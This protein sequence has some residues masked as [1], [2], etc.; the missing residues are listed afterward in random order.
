MIYLVTNSKELFTNDTYTII[1]VEESLKLLEPLR[2]VGLDT[3]TDGLNCWSNKLK[4]IQLG[5]YDFQVVIDCLT[6]SPGKYKSYLESDRLFIGHNIKFDLCFLFRK[7]IWPRNVY[8]TYLGEKLLWLG[9]PIKLKPEVWSRIQCDRYTAKVSDSGNVSGYILEMNLKK[10]G[11]LYLGIELDKT[12]R[13][14]IIYAGLT[15]EVVVY[16][17]LDV[18]Y[19]E[20][21]MEAQKKKL[22]EQRLLNAIKYE[23]AFTVPLAY[24]E[25]CGV[26]INTTK[27]KAKMEKDNQRKQALEEQLNKWLITNMPK[28]KYITV[29]TQ[30]NLFEGFDTKPKVT[31][32]WNST[33]QLIPLFKSLGVDVETVDKGEEKDSL[34]A[35]VLGPQKD[36][37]ALIPIYLSYKEAVKVT[38]TYGQNFLDQINPVSGRIHTKFQVIGTDTDRISSGGK[39]S[40]GTKLINFLNIPSDAET[41]ECFEAEDGNRWISIDYIGQETYLMASI[42]NDKA[43]IKEL[44]EGSG[45]IHSLT[46]YISYMDIP[47]DTPIKD[48]KKLYHNRRQDAKGIEFAIN[49]GGDANTIHQNTGL[50]L[51]QCKSIYNNYMSGFSGLASYQKFR[52]KDWWDK[53]YILLNSKTGH[54]A[55]IYDY[56]TLVKEYKSFQ[57]EGFWDYYRN[58]KKSDPKSYTIQK[59]KKFFKRKADS[60]KQSI[61]YVIQ[62]AGALCSKVSI[63]NFFKYLREN[64][65]LNK[66]KI[67]ILPYDEANV[68]APEEIAEEVAKKLYDCMVEAGAYFCTRCKLDAEISRLPDGSLPTYWIH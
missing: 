47:R 37:T 9:Y 14:K 3:E 50:P 28:S 24:M 48:I 43:I 66:V 60:E 57:E 33:Q 10:L 63:I 49:Y 7:D 68:E 5:C 22:K 67:C 19:L 61:N 23:N 16:S 18:K 62:N 46:A 1:S 32:N 36:K 51:E 52:R 31:L 38:S 26:K 27:W 21:L 58:L 39:E 12:V 30:G 20:K 40:N 29:N 2:I 45:D 11:E 53:G 64:N 35:K 42:S 55:Y 56:D 25:Y 8:D 34:E 59:V 15:D 44:T 6:V 4:T 13:G 54:K 65:L 41:R 17:A